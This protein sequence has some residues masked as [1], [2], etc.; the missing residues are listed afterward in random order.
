[1]Q[2]D[3]ASWDIHADVRVNGAAPPM[4]SG[5][6]W[7]V[8]FIQNVVRVDARFQYDGGR[9]VTVNS[10]QPRLDAERLQQA[11]VGAPG[12]GVFPWVEFIFQGRDKP[13]NLAVDFNDHPRVAYFNFFGGGSVRGDQLREARDQ[14]T[15]RCWLAARPAAAPPN[16]PGRFHLLQVVTFT[17]TLEITI[18]SGGINDVFRYAYEQALAGTGQ[19]L[20]ARSIPG[21]TVRPITAQWG[22][23]LRT[24]PTPIVS[25]PLAN[26][27]LPGVYA[28]S[29]VSPRELPSLTTPTHV[30]RPPRRG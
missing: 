15:F 2:V 20:P 17:V 6:R 9:V 11:W 1:M 19:S 5:E 21:V 27:V 30:Y 13:F 28:D 4:A 24:T 18:P 22:P 8:G 25:G 29:G 26:D 23:I 12:G 14:T 16:L 7:Q 10:A 3:G